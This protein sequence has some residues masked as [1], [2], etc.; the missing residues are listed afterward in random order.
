MA[1]LE[2]LAEL[3]V[4]D[5]VAAGVPDD[6]GEHP[7]ARIVCGV[8]LLWVREGMQGLGSVCG[9]DVHASDERLVNVYARDVGGMRILGLIPG[10]VPV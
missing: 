6:F 7:Q 2:G 1:L 4:P 9:R 3:A 10:C 5:L 8:A